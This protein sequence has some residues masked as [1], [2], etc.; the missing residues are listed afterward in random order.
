MERFMK[1]F[2]SKSFLV[3]FA[4]AVLSACTSKPSGTDGLRPGEK[5]GAGVA[6]ATAP[7]GE[8]QYAIEI[9][10][11]DATRRS[12]LY[13]VP[14]G[15]NLSG[16][17]IEWLVDGMPVDG[18]N[19]TA[20]S[21]AKAKKGS[22]VQARVTVKGTEMRSNQV[23]IGNSPPEITGGHF[24]LSG[25]TLA[26]DVT[27]ADADEDSVSLTYAWSVNDKP[28]GTGKTLDA[29]VKRGDKISV[30]IV[31]SDGESDGRPVILTSEARNMAPILTEQKDVRFDGKIWTCQ[32]NAVDH[33]GDA[34]TYGIKSGPPGMTID[35]Q[36]GLMTWHVPDD[37]KGKTS[38]IAVVKD[39]HGGETSYTV[40]IDISDVT[41]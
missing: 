25:N 28:A 34:V 39:S 35:A 23:T 18:A 22:V 11:K 15:L 2:F 20:F 30:K 12:A 40:N 32:L 41:K 21:A 3:L 26:V 1:S 4:L 33:D 24:L 38:C 10:P 5:G 14:K 27:T 16:A 17:E 19:A 36:T 13:I 9:A 6:S 29:H 37:F 7:A 31:P 8:G